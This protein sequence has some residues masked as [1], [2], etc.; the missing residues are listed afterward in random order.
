MQ[1]FAFTI[2]AFFPSSISILQVL[3]LVGRSMMQLWRYKNMLWSHL[4]GNLF[5]S[6]CFFLIPIKFVID[7]KFLFLILNIIFLVIFVFLYFDR[8]VNAISRRKYGRFVRWRT[9]SIVFRNFL[10]CMLLVFAPNSG[11]N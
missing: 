3:L 2:Y 6:Q 1:N 5:I 9:W 8:W 10:K 4:N 7:E 11:R